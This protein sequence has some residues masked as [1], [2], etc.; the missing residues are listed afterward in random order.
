M[1]IANGFLLPADFGREYYFDLAVGRCGRCQM[2]QLLERVDPRRLFHDSYAYFSS[3][4][5][6]MAEH[7]Q[8][9]ARWLRDGWLPGTDPFVV[10]VGSND[11]ILLRHLAGAG[12]RHVGIEPSANVAEAARSRGVWTLSRFFDEG[13]ARELLD[14][15][16]AADAVIGANVVCHLSDLHSFV[17]G[18]L[19]L[20]S[21]RGVLVFEEPWLGAVV[22]TTA[23]DQIY[24][25]H[26][27]YFS[28]AALG[29]LFSGY[30][31]EIV[32]ALPQPVHGGS[33]RFVAARRGAR[34]VSSRVAELSERELRLGL[35]EP[36]TYEAFRSRVHASRDALL[37]LL[38]GIKRAGHSVVGY[39]A[40][41]KS[42]TV[43]NFCGIGPQVLDYVCDTT[44]GKQGRFT[45]GQHVPVRPHEVFRR[46][47]PEYA[48]LFAWN[49]AA[50]ILAKEQDFQARGG[51]FLVYVPEV[52]VLEPALL[53]A[54]R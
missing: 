28:L 36:R 3:T 19:A 24:D 6:H 11:G 15:H 51:R 54:Q 1:P 10:E 45:P 12:I 35:G 49:H 14:S 7:F 4:S 8:S 23:W 46:Q 13:L 2:V 50:E 39:G 22:A 9:Y 27:F 41:S 30:D 33:M 40:T 31:V 43:L 44:P 26:V 20:L 32:D 52:R 53:T 18:A 21:P 42:T 16:G 34:P 47:P 5:A 37:D 29:Q 48:L 17:R 38:Q 25:E